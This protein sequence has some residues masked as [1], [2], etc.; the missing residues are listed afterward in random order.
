MF[1]TIFVTGGEYLTVKDE[2]LLINYGDTVK[3]VPLSDIKNLFIDNVYINMSVYTLQKLAKYGIDAII[4]DET[5]L[6]CSNIL[7]LNTHYKPYSVLKKQ[8]ALTDSFKNLLWQKII[9][10]KIVNQCAALKI[11]GSGTKVCDRMKQLAMEVLIGDTGNRE[12]IAAKMFF[13]NLYGYDFIRFED[14]IINSALN[15]GYAVIRSSVAR[16]LCAYGYNCA[17]GIHHISETNP[18]NLADDLMEPLRPLADIWV[19]RN[20]EN[21]IDTL[22]KNNR[23]GLAN[24]LNEDI[25]CGNKIMKVHNAVDKYIASLTTAIDNA[26]VNRLIIPVLGEAFV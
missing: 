20:N 8:I 24:I 17:L 10:A 15:Y 3:K 25:I 18:F 19:Y 21:L 7:P 14:N 22:S 6:P 16:A 11:S 2:W 26:D 4:C 23:I 9:K 12:G 1:R 13:R 5:H